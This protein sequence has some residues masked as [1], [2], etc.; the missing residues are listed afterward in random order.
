MDVLEQDLLFSNREPSEEERLMLELGIATLTAAAAEVA[1]AV[2]SCKTRDRTGDS[3]DMDAAEAQVLLRIVPSASTM[4]RLG[5][6]QQRIRRYRSALSASR[7]LPVEVLQIIFRQLLPDY[8]RISVYEA[9]LLLTRVC[10][11]WRETALVTP[12]LWSSIHIVCQ[13]FVRDMRYYPGLFATKQR[14]LKGVASWI[15]RSRDLPLDIRIDGPKLVPTRRYRTQDLLQDRLDVSTLISVLELLLPHRRRWRTLD[16]AADAR[17]LRALERVDATEVP[18]LVAFACREHKTLH[19]GTFPFHHCVGGAPLL[20]R[21]CIASPC[22]TGVQTLLDAPHW[23]HQLI[24]FD[25]CSTYDGRNA[26]AIA[27]VLATISRLHSLER[28]SVK[29]ER[30]HGGSYVW[31]PSFLIP[32]G[33]PALLKKL[34]W[35]S[36]SCDDCVLTPLL[37]DRLKAPHLAEIE[38]NTRRHENIEPFAEFLSRSEAPLKSMRLGIKR[39]HRKYD[40]CLR[41]TPSLE[42]LVVTGLNPYIAKSVQLNRVTPKLDYDPTLDMCP[43]LR[44]VEF[45]DVWGIDGEWLL[46]FLLTRALHDVALQSVIVRFGYQPSDSLEKQIKPYMERGT[47]VTLLW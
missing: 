11:L 39:W 45:W 21:L 25:F 33:E 19:P 22:H 27:T 16:I 1:N 37:L 29:L 8:A 24:D 15:A 9:P 40:D 23:Q 38:Y 34:S 2:E 42:H 14:I 36:I 46:D 47:K 18:N 31:E 12:E 20:S 30:A 3:A 41:I 5:G 32:F 28:L 17:L 4:L 44:S 6:I 43:R 7:R 10:R 13:P 35:L 26:N